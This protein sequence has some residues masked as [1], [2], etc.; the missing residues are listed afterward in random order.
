MIKTKKPAGINKWLI[1][2]NEELYLK[3]IAGLGP[4]FIYT[5]FQA[6]HFNS[7]EDALALIDQYEQLTNCTAIEVK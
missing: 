5:K 1:K 2:N 7:K 3:Q 6:K 4:I